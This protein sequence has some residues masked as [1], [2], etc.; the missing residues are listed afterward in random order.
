MNK[1]LCLVAVASALLAALSG[2]ATFSSNKSADPAVQAKT[3]P[4]ADYSEFT[5][6][7]WL[8]ETSARPPLQL[9]ALSLSTQEILAAGVYKFD[10]Q[11][12]SS[13]SISK[14]NKA[15]NYRIVE[16]AVPP[17]ESALSFGTG[18]D[19]LFRNG[20]PVTNITTASIKDLPDGR[21]M[22]HTSNPAAS[23][24]AVSF[25][26][27]DVSG[28]EVRQLLRDT[29]NQP[30]DLAW[31]VKKSFVFPK[32]SRV[33]LPTFWLGDDE[34]VKTSRTAFTGATSMSDL[35]SR[36]NLAHSPFCISYVSF[37]DAHP[38]ALSFLD[39]GK[40]LGTSGSFVLFP[41][42]R[43]SNICS[44]KSPTQEATGTWKIRSIHGT[45]VMELTPEAKVKSENVGVQPI[46][47]NSVTNGF[48]ELVRGTTGKGKRM[49]TITTVVPVRILRNNQP[50]V[51]FR[52]RFNDVAA[53]AVR[54][55]L[56]DAVVQQAKDQ[57]TTK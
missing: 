28:K 23:N 27:F 6:V 20:K 19:T 46:N 52:L 5:D 43:S 31:Y 50:I 26:A 40:K 16:K 54:A 49:K 36:F 3:G 25:K 13:F 7:T 45:T 51:D 42:D 9:P 38:Y 34:I 56:A 1:R 30:T 15:G 21:M 55:A 35:V 24:V 57:Q 44:K 47:A 2:C 32:G 18:T 53:G 11:R 4:R 37:G 17:A 39:A 33:Y 8:P 10:G 41:M 22:V 14:G 29:N 12:E 48:A